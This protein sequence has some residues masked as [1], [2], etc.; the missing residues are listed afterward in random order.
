MI[1]DRDT[2]RSTVGTIKTA[3]W[4]GGRESV[5]W[6]GDAVSDLR[7][8]KGK[9]Y[10]ALT[11]VSMCHDPWMIYPRRINCKR[12]PWLTQSG[13]SKNYVR[14]SNDQLKT[15]QPKT[16]LTNLW[17][18]N[19]WWVDLREEIKAFLTRRWPLKMGGK[20]L[21]RSLLYLFFNFGW[22]V[23]L[24]AVLEYISG[25]IRTRIAQHLIH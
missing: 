16:Y 5:R 6:P 9:T 25:P 19:L 22:S 24:P 7:K 3:V 14:P 18:T 10:S 15:Y 23:F 1:G 2:R 4:R 17:P 20:R 12:Q 21:S 13:H 8:L 11:E